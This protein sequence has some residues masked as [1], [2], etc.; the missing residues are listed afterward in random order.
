MSSFNSIIAII[1]T[2]AVLIIVI[3]LANLFLRILNKNMTRTQKIIK[4]VERT[5]VF[6]NSALAVV[7]ICGKYYLMSF[8][9]KDN[10][11][12]RELEKDEVESY[13]D[14]LKDNPAIMDFKDKANLYFGMR[15]KS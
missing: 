14:Q 12:L 2:I 6:N 8:T 11:I 15:K 13:L 7:E 3:I 10:K 1:Q 9:D 4:I 5:Y